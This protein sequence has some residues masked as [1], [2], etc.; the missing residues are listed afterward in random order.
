MTEASDRTGDVKPNIKAPTPPPAPAGIDLLGVRLAR[1]ASELC[2]AFSL[3]A[4]PPREAAYRVGLRQSGHGDAGTSIEVMAVLGHGAPYVKLGYPGADERSDGG[5]V[6]ADV[7][8]SGTNVGFRLD[9]STFPSWTP[10]AGDFDW[11]ASS[12]GFGDQPNLQYSD[13]A[14]ETTGHVAYPGGRIVRIELSRGTC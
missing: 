12:L 4:P 1:S 7:R 8:V 14:P 10:P 13:C 11:E 2:V 5:I 3:E 6:D 9:T